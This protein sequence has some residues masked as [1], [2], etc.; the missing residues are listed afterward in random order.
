MKNKLFDHLNYVESPITYAESMKDIEP[1]KWMKPV[2]EG[3]KQNDIIVR[4]GSSPL[5]ERIEMDVTVAIYFE[6]SDSEMYGGEGSIGYSQVNLDYDNLDKL[7]KVT[8]DTIADL[9]CGVAEMLKVTD[10]HVKI[11]SRFEY[12]ENTED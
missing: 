8:S 7:R 4:Q 3:K 1:I 10:D 11:I 6:I 2:R 5:P 12:E 9:K